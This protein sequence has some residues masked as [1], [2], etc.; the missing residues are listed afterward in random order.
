MILFLLN[1]IVANFAISMAVLLLFT[2]ADGISQP[3]KDKFTFKLLVNQGSSSNIEIINLVNEE[4]T[5]S[6]SDGVFTISGKVGDLL[7]I[8]GR[9]FELKRYIIDPDDLLAEIINIQLIS[10]AIELNET[11]VTSTSNINARALGI[12]P[13]STPIYTPAERKLKTAG[14][15]KPIDF[16]GLLLGGMPL[17]PIFNAINGKTAA[18]KKQIII[19]TRENRIEQYEV[20]F[21]TD[22]FVNKLSIPNVHIKGFLFYVS[23]NGKLQHSIKNGDLNTAKFILSKSAVDY[24]NIHIKE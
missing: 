20:L 6:N 2:S 16:L 7:L 4:A 1:S 12:I 8:S 14:D 9:D 22:Y 11:V 17:D 19:E 23:E 5:R 10:K 24:K 13:E 18:L 21:G 3:A 15:L